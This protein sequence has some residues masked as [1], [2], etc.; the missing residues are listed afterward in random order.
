MIEGRPQVLIHNG[1]LYDAVLREAKLT[2]HELHAALRQ[3]GCDSVDDVHLAVLE[4]N[5][6][7]SVVQRRRD[8]PPM[9]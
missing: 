6:S 7:I 2:R 1:Q 3:N 4:N 8:M 5:G 9:D